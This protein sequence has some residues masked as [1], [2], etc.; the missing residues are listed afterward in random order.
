MDDPV[1]CRNDAL[2]L[3]LFLLLF[4]FLLVIITGE[5]VLGILKSLV[6]IQLIFFFL[7]FRAVLV[8]R[9]INVPLKFCLNFI[10]IDITNERIVRGDLNGHEGW[11]AALALHVLHDLVIQ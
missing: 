5:P 11:F 6:L 4:R 9:L 7:L 8:P 1:G 10:D 2:G 3:D